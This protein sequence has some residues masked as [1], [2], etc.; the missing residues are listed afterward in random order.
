M[1]WNWL[2]AFIID[3]LREL[4]RQR[5]EKF[6]RPVL[7]VP[8]PLPPEYLP[9]ENEPEDKPSREPVIIDMATYEIFDRDE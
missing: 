3:K 5:E 6:E 7:H 1:K 9:P 8:A 4:E 2:P